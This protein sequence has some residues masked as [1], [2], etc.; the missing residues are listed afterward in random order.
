MEEFLI[1]TNEI[2]LLHRVVSVVPE[3]PKELQDIKTNL[4]HLLAVSGNERVHLH[5]II[6]VFAVMHVPGVAIDVNGCE[7]VADGVDFADIGKPSKSESGNEGS[8][9][10]KKFTKP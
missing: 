4:R 7:R 6:L 3:P 10:Q 9:V 8:I 5:F 2:L 1:L